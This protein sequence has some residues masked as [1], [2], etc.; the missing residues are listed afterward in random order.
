MPSPTECQVNLGY[1]SVQELSDFE[2]EMRKNNTS[3]AMQKL[4]NM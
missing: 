4:S 3:R 1:N 2:F